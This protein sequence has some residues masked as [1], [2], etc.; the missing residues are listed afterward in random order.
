MIKIDKDIARLQSDTKTL[1]KKYDTLENEIR[2]LRKLY[3]LLY[4]ISANVSEVAILTEHN[5]KQIKQLDVNYEKLHNKWLNH[6]IEGRDS[7][8]QSSR[9]IRENIISWV[10]VFLL[11]ALAVYFFGDIL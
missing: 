9:F 7:K 1:F 8:I 2:D 11:G 6:E 4:N 5:T 10:I 3:D